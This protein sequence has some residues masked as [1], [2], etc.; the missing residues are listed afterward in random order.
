[1]LLFGVGRFTGN[2]VLA[3][4]FSA[5]PAQPRGYL[6]RAQSSAGF[7]RLEWFVTHSRG[8]VFEIERTAGANSWQRV[9]DAG[10]DPAG[11][12]SGEDRSVVP[13][14]RYGYRLRTRPPDG[15]AGEVVS[16]ESWVE[17]PVAPLLAFV[18]LGPNPWKGGFEVSF[19]LGDGGSASIDILDIAGRV[20]ISRAVG[21]LGAGRHT[22]ELAEPNQLAPGLYFLRL[23]SQH[24]SVSQRQVVIR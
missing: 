9:A 12:V 2:E 16:P 23:K 7:A 14:T 5:L 1:M 11:H 22:L 19:E 8:R 17:I 18:S 6:V 4:K 21:H 13:G 10:A 20:R 3:L 15:G 24:G